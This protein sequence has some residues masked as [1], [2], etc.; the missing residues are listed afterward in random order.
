MKLREFLPREATG[1]EYRDTAVCRM[2]DVE[3]VEQ[4]EG[5]EK[6]WPG[7]EKHVFH[8]CL[9]RTGHAVGWNENPARGWSFPVLSPRFLRKQNGAKT[10]KR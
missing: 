9:L 3:I 4:F 1:V 10:I 5:F 8:W 6:R 7:R 2:A